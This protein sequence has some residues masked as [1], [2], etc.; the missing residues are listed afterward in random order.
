LKWEVRKEKI[1]LSLIIVTKVQS[2]MVKSYDDGKLG[3][4]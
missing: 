1:K 2:A 4:K 3:S